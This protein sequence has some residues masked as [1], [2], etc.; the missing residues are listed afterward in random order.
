MIDFQ[1]IDYKGEDRI[2]NADSRE[3]RNIGKRLEEVSEGRVVF[4]WAEDAPSGN[5]SRELTTITN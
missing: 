2:D 3:K 5:L 1:R 4:W